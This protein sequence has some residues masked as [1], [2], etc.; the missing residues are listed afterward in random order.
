MSWISRSDENSIKSSFQLKKKKCFC[1]RSVVSRSD[2][3]SIKSSFQLKY[4]YQYFFTITGSKSGLEK[5]GSCIEGRAI[6]VR[7]RSLCW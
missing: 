1:R 4:N 5:E 2:E 7:A 6:C 3:N